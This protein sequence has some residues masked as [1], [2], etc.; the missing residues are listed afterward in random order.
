MF[1]IE[2]LAGL[3]IG[4]ALMLSVRHLQFGIYMVPISVAIGPL[5]MKLLGRT[6]SKAFLAL[7]IVIA[8]TLFTLIA[9]TSP[10]FRNSFDPP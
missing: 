1:V 7:Y 2:S 3:V 9:L 6:P 10:G 5:L 4:A 8:G